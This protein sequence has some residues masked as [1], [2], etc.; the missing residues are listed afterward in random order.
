MFPETGDGIDS[1]AEDGVNRKEGASHT[2]SRQ[3]EARQ[4]TNDMIGQSYMC[5]GLTMRTDV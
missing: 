1:F 2:N 3:H 5:E 4:M